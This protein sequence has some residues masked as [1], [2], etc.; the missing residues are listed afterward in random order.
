MGEIMFGVEIFPLRFKST[1]AIRENTLH[2]R[3]TTTKITWAD[4]FYRFII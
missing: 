4:T 1:V 3:G 2:D